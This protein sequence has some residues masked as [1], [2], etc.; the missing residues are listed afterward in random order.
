M[1]VGIH[2]GDQ[3]VAGRLLGQAYQAVHP[4]HL[5]VTTGEAQWHGKQ[6]RQRKT[7]GMIEPCA[8]HEADLADDDEGQPV[9]R[10]GQ[11]LVTP[12]HTALACIETRI[13]RLGSL[14]LLA[15]GFGAHRLIAD[16]VAL[17]VEHWGYVGIDPVMVTVL[18]S[19]LDDAHP[20]PAVLERAP[21]VREHGGRHV[22]MTYQVVRSADQV[23]AV[24]AADFGEGVVAV[25]DLAFQVR[26]RNQPLLI[27]KCVFA[28]GDG[29]VVSHESAPGSRGG[30]SHEI[31]PG[32][33]K[34][35]F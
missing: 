4:A 11:P 32:R 8:D 24:I 2:L 30:P 9:D 16:D 22:R 10:H 23:G 17:H 18:A 33:S 35:H 5:P 28:L 19:I 26:G 21:H 15:G 34:R 3:G 29:L 31:G 20:G 14:D 27:G 7:P 6:C 13:E 25:G 1:A 12:R